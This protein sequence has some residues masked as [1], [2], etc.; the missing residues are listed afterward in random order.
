MLDAKTVLNRREEAIQRWDSLG[1]DGAAIVDELAALD[2]ARKKH[3]QAHDDEKHRQSSLSAIFRDKTASPEAVQEARVELRTLGDTI[4][5][6]ANA[7]K[8][9]EHAL[10]IRLMELPNWPHESVPVGPDE[11]ANALTRTF[12]EPPTLDFE[13]KPHWEIAENLGIVDFEAA[14]SISGARFVVYRG[15]GARLERA[16]ANFMLDMHTGEH[17]YEETLTPFLV[18]R[19]AMEGTGQLPKFEDDAFQTTDGLFLIPTSEVSVTNL[20]RGQML[21]A[22]DLPKKYAAYSSCFRREAGS[23]GRDVKGLT[24]VHQFQKVEMVKLCSEDTSYAE[25]ESMV[26]NAEAVLQKLELPYRVM[27]LCTGDLGFSAAKTY[28]IEVFLPGH[29]GFREISSCSN[30]ESWQARR[31]DIR[32]RPAPGEK[33][34]YVHTLNGS[35]LAIGRTI[36]AILENG[37]QSD[38]TV[39]I[40]A[41]LQPYMG[42]VDVLTSKN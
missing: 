39:R 42:G 30:C 18:K 3:I 1:L 21:D 2:A 11:T 34:R 4:K 5:E 10:R 29:N 27:A 26:S 9:A 13:P 16:L 15:Q 37:Q 6:H 24:R 8:D 40:P 23:Y 33:P 31:A 19:E 25:L 17:G 32:Y 35:G 41:A 38:G 7:A 12:G 14:A 28:D 20:H 22:A 36:V